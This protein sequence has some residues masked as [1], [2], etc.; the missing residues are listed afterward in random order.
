MALTLVALHCIQKNRDKCDLN[1]L[2]ETKMYD[3][4]ITSMQF[5]C[6]IKS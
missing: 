5:M 3:L 4:L 1:H 6:L 2:L